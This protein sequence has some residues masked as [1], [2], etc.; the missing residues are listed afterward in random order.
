M[1]YC[2]ENCIHCAI[3]FRYSQ[4]ASSVDDAV[5]SGLKPEATSKNGVSNRESKRFISLFVIQIFIS[6]IVYATKN[7]EDFNSYVYTM[8]NI[9]REGEADLT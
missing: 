8:T 9:R 5:Q 3:E 4:L 7:P 6:L 2:N 1:E